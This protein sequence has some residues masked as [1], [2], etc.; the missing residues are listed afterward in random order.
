MSRTRLIQSATCL[1]SQIVPGALGSG[2]PSLKFSVSCGLGTL[3]KLLMRV[4]EA[5]LELK[6]EGG[7]LQRPR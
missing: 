2:K 3:A 7:D 4:E 6:L 1:L 5:R